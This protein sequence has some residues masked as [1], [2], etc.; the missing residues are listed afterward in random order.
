[1]NGTR[2]FFKASGISLL[3]FV[4]LVN[5]CTQYVPEIGK[6][7]DPEMSVI[8]TEY[9]GGYE[10]RYVEFYV[11]Q[12]KDIKERI[13]AY[14]LVPDNARSSERLPAVVM[15]H[16]HGARFDIGKE[17]LVRPMTSILP[18][19]N[20]DHILKSSAQWVDKYFDGVY[21]ADSLAGLG[22]VVLVADALYW[23]ERASSEAHRWSELSFGDQKYAA[24][25][26][27]KALKNRVYEGQRTIYD[28]LIENNVIW[29]EKILR[30]DVASVRLLSSLPYVDKKKIGAFGFSMGAHRSWM[31][32]AFC[33]DVKCGVALSWMT[34]L[35]RE[36]EMSASDYSMAIMP[37]RSKMDFGDI[38]KYLAPKPMFF[39]SG[40]SDHLFPVEK[41][42]HAYDILQGYYSEC[43]ER[44]VTAFFNGGHHCGKDVQAQIFQYLD[45]NLK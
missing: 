27:L 24:K 15:L 35:E 42:K 20:D 23:G 28:S 4:I 8:S 39:L 17:K 38:G 10:C 13:K 45:Y 9:R 32:S 3:I 33:K 11:G 44:L 14:L 2:K 25:D 5:S 34:T 26:T 31:L 41:T 21:L 30:D 19:G 22:Y 16:D 37:M 6:L 1:M 40:D 12:A 36:A 18:E 43:P 7:V 29:A